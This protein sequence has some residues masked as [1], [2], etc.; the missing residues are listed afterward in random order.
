MDSKL[1]IYLVSLRTA[2]GPAF[3]TLHTTTSAMLACFGLWFPHLHCE[4][5][6]AAAAAC[7][8]PP[9]QP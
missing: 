6:H 5:T 7:A 4:L 1:V 9:R 8:F 2:A 3:E